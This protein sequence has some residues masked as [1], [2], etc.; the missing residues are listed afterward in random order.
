M[1]KGSAVLR[2]DIRLGEKAEDFGKHK[3]GLYSF[4][5]ILL[6]KSIDLCY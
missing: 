5:D 4:W 1:T 3:T 2:R 6:R